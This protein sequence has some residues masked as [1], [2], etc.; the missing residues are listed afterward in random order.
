MKAGAAVVGEKYLSKNGTPVKVV[1]FKDDKVVLYSEVT[2]MNIPVSKN[3]PLREY[4]EPEHPLSTESMKDKV[5]ALM[6]SIGSPTPKETVKVKPK[7]ETIASVIDPYLLEGDGRTVKE[8]VKLIEKRKL[9]I[10]EG[11]DVS[12]NIRAR[13][14][15]YSR[16]GYSIEKSAD[17]KVKVIEPAK[18]IR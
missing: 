11:K 15:A 2:R 13:M 6:D 1:E 9:A 4:K 18:H 12:A 17:K 10:M 7:G 16:K 5:N 8:I 14:V 3:Y